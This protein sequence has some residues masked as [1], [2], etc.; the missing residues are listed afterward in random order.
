MPVA[1]G[2][3][4]AR[5]AQSQTIPGSAAVL[6]SN[7]RFYATIDDAATLVVFERLGA[8]S[9]YQ[10]ASGTT[11]D[12]A[13]VT[14]DGTLWSGSRFGA[15]LSADGSQVAFLYGN[16]RQVYLVGSDGKGLRQITSLPEAVHEV[17]LSGDGKVA[18][19]V[20]VQNR[21]VRIDVASATSTEIV[22]AIPYVTNPFSQVGRGSLSTVTGAGFATGTAQAT[23]PYPASLGGVQVSIGGRAAGIAA[24]SPTS[25]SY[26]VPWDAPIGVFEVEIE[27]ASAAASP[28]VPGVEV[29]SFPPESYTTIAPGT[30]FMQVAVHE[31]FSSLVSVASPAR[32]GEVLHLYAHDLGPVSPAPPAGLPAPLRPV[33]ALT[34]SL[35]CTL[36]AEPGVVSVPVEVLFAGLGPTLTGVFQVDVRMPAVFTSDLGALLCQVGTPAEGYACSDVVLNCT[37][38]GYVNL[39]PGAAQSSR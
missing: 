2:L 1:G 19:A 29:T 6:D 9:V 27:S 13:T 30:P 20:T 32:P 15:S 11:L 5:G 14:L 31:D 34:V 26:G 25:L 36:R 24:V 16:N 4:V 18:F 39:A 3:V 21:I 8:L 33:S 10:V 12:L 23:A 35:A 37:I 22:A 17:A 7:G 38:G 28:L